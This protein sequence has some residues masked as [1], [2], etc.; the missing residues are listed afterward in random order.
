MRELI[1]SQLF[2]PGALALLGGF[3]RVI[4]KGEAKTIPQVIGAMCASE[5]VGV[6]VFLFIHDF[7]IP[8]GMKA[9]FVGIAGFSAPTLLP[10]AEKWLVNELKKKPTEK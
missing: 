2:L 6:M 5:F 7:Q 8:I 3:V 4:Y 10:H 1:D 9:A